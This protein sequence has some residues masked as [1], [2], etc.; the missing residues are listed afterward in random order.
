MQEFLQQLREQ[1]T[2]IWDQLP[3][4]QK[5]I[6]V[7]APTI[8]LVAMIIAIYLASR[9]QYVNLVRTENEQ[10]LAQITQYLESENINYELAGTNAVQVDESQVNRVRLQLANE[11][12]IGPQTGPGFELFDQVSLGMTDRMF[13]IQAKRALENK[14]VRTIIDGDPAITNAHVS[15]VIPQRELF[16]EDQAVPT[17]S[18]KITS[19]TR[20]SQRSVKGIQ[21]LL[22][23]SVEKM[24]PEN[25][26][27]LDSSNRTLSENEEVN[28]KFKLASRQLEVQQQIESY[29]QSKL[30]SQLEPTVGTDNYRIA[31]TA[32]LDWEKKQTK[33]V[34]IQSDSP[35]P[36]SNKTYSEETTTKGITGPPGVASNVQDS[37]I[38]PESETTGT[39]IEEEIVNNQFPWLESMTEEEIGEIKELSVSV[40]VNYRLN[41]EGE[42]EPRPEDWATEMEE[43]L[44]VA[45]G[46]PV[47]PV[48]NAPYSFKLTQVEFDRSEEVARLWEERWNMVIGI[49]QSLLPLLLLAAL[50]YFAY[51]FFQRAFAPAEI[52]HEE[53]EEVPIE[54]V[55]E[56]KE[57]SL[58]QLGLAEFGDIASLPAEEQRRVKMQEHVINYA[59]EKPE[60][61]AAIIKAWLSS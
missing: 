10:Q 53:E 29:L 43:T 33:Q 40:M 45:A 49:V 61:V 52:E 31:V 35:A 32:V 34:E 1:L 44:R 5:V 2:R 22:S 36:V 41:D 19:R 51:V 17:A 25:V 23:A 46:M 18:V 55:T 56:A 20:I 8:L 60:E 16:K 47:Q 42:R 59:A 4:Q 28:S 38:G 7:A 3:P 58:S 27:I 13:D 30:A 21:N 57:L 24:R 48:A 15:I 39:T 6:F 54:P 12:L 11:G 14:L 37:G 50:S 9:P 26:V